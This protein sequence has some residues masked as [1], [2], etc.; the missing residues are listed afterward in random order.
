[1][2]DLIAVVAMSAIYP[3][4]IGADALWQTALNRQRCFR[5]IPAVRLPLDEY[6]STTNQEDSV[7]VA[8]AGLIEG[9]EFDLQQ[10]RIPRDLHAATDTTHWLALDACR[11]LLD[12]LGGEPPANPDRVGVVIGNSLT[13]EVSRANSI[14]L[15]WPYIQRVVQSVSDSAGLALPQGWMQQLE[16]AFKEPMPVPGSDTLAGGLSNTIAGRLTNYFDFHGLGYT[17]DGACASSLL[18]VMHAQSLLRDR[19]LDLAIAGGVDMSIDPFEM[20]GFSRLGALAGDTMR[21][22]DQS[23]TGFFP[24]EGCGLVA[25]MRHEDARKADVPVLAVL[26]GSGVSSD[27]A[28]GLTRPAESGHRM[29]AQRAYRQADV[30]PNDIGLFEGHGTGT[31]VGDIAELNVFHQ[32]R[33]PDATSAAVGSIKANIG[34][35]KAAAGVAGLIKTI[36]AVNQAI[37]PPT[38]GVDQPH[39]IFQQISNLRITHE[40]E[41]WKSTKRVAAV[42]ALGFG[43]INTHLVVANEPNSRRP[44]KM[45]QRWSSGEFGLLV[46]T[47][48]TVSEVKDILT[49]LTHKAA[50]FSDADCV[51]AAQTATRHANPQA[52]VRVAFAVTGRHSLRRAV[53]VATDRLAAIGGAGR[54]FHCDSDVAIGIGNPGR[55][56]ALFPGQGAPFQRHAPAVTEVLP[57]DSAWTQAATEALSAASSTVGSGTDVAQP[58]I[59]AAEMVGISWLE[60]IGAVP[61]G[62]VGHSLGELTAL[63]WA[64]MMTP[65]EAIELAVARGSAMQKYGV[66][67]TGMLAIDTDPDSA[68]VLAEQALAGGG[69]CELAAYNG[70]RQSV[71]GGPDKELDQLAEYAR[72][73]HILTHRLPVSHAFHT[74]AMKPAIDPYSA[75]IERVEWRQANP[76]NQVYSTVSGE[77]VTAVDDATNLLRRQLTNPVRLTQALQ[78]VTSDVD[79]LVEVGPGKTLSAAAKQFVDMPVVAMELQ[80]GVAGIGQ[81]TAALV[82]LGAVHTLDPWTTLAPQNERSFDH[83][84]RLLPSPLGMTETDLSHLQPASAVTE[85][86][87]ATEPTDNE[88]ASSID[89]ATPSTVPRTAS[90]HDETPDIASPPQPEPH[91]APSPDKS[92][93]D[94]DISRDDAAQIL[95]DALATATSLD[96]DQV[97]DQDRLSAD[98]HLNSLQINHLFAEVAAQAGRQVPSDPTGLAEG[99]VG[100]ALDLLMAL[101]GSDSADATA[102]L[103]APWVHT[104]TDTW[105][106]VEQPATAP[107]AAAPWSQS[108]PEGF[109]HDPEST[110]VHIVLPDN[111]GVEDLLRMRDVVAQ[112][113]D[114]IVVDH[115]G[116]GPAAA[117]VL[118]HETSAHP[119]GWT[120]VHRSDSKQ[121]DLEVVQKLPSGAFNDLKIDEDGQLYRRHSERIRTSDS[122]FRH[123]TGTDPLV[124]V[125]GGVNGIMAECA[126]ELAQNTNA[127]LLFVGRT[128]REDPAIIAALEG[129]AM[130]GIVADYRSLDV[131]SRTSVAEAL[132]SVT[133]HVQGIL[134][135][136]AINTPQRADQVTASALKA[137]SQAKVDGLHNLLEVIDASHLELV[138]TFGSIIE[139]AGLAGQLA[140]AHANEG[141]RR[142]TEDLATHSAAKVLHMQW[143]IW[144]DI[145]MGQDL[146]VL[147]SMRRRGVIPISPEAGRRH[148]WQQLTQGGPTTRLVMGRYPKQPTLEFAT[149]A[150][151]RALRYLEEVLTHIPETEL[152]VS[153]ELSAPTDKALQAHQIAGVS[154]LP[155]VC[156]LEAAAQVATTL[157]PELSWT[158]FRNLEILK[159]V[160]LS[161]TA[162]RATLTVSV[163]DLGSA[164][165]LRV[166]IGDD[167]GDVALMDIHCGSSCEKSWSPGGFAG[168]DSELYGPLYFH[169]E[170]F[171]R[172]DRIQHVTASGLQAQLDTRPA[173]WFSP[174]LSQELV[175][176]DVGVL[177]AT[178]HALQACFP[179]R[180]LLPVGADTVKVHN[181]A[182]DGPCLLEA[183]ELL[184]RGGDLCFDV[185]LTDGYGQPVISWEGLRLRQSHCLAGVANL[186]LMGPAIARHVRS[187]DWPGQ[188]DLVVSAAEDPAEDVVRYL[189]G[190][191]AGHDSAG[192]LWCRPGYTSTSKSGGFRLT[193]WSDEQRVGVDW[194]VDAA[195]LPR[196]SGEY[197][198]ALA[199][200]GRE[201]PERTAALVMWTALEAAKKTQLSYQG[202]SVTNVRP[203]EG[204]GT[205]ISLASGEVAVEVVVLTVSQR[206][207]VAGIGVSK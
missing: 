115:C 172:V 202:L 121:L 19:S 58:A 190:R 40:P 106:L 187:L 175:L 122:D 23:P 131:T 51:A 81:T 199:A 10:Y 143:S 74:Q 138:V 17:V 53:R 15:R 21:I 177:D 120:L 47:A 129:L 161:S 207:V 56:A 66:G 57:Q 113:W 85:P 176:G 194:E 108:T 48:D 101:P 149:A 69:T 200:L 92:P 191:E 76:D 197:D 147:D 84:P 173:T 97:T 159:P 75:A 181:P 25:L 196:L 55:F 160:S 118:F 163:A 105:T 184:P 4:G 185:D 104:F 127:R 37:I 174:F 50:Q 151:T 2:S 61:S 27:G 7:G 11:R 152:T 205:G 180:Q 156:A 116:A 39:Q 133:D 135:G 22:Y 102:L 36:N 182:P 144:S 136:A 18:S 125:T 79:L 130:R 14:R 77:V 71:I 158:T 132:G 204:L 186:E 30:Q 44:T 88:T 142:A 141:L 1:M 31:A 139:R 183:S 87:I 62:A 12:E 35:T 54:Y 145:G 112:G 34:H 126:T 193:A 64:Q 96:A 103:A 6:A 5:D 123:F 192:R 155:T 195:E 203:V 146:G 206:H 26:A 43:G 94:A 28:G 170:A 189:T 157:K 59:V 95:I 33:D 165:R 171:Q 86:S 52:R 153:G 24:G 168:V 114:R 13:G 16:E 148:F 140:Y 20:V 9:W 119:H 169:R 49:G 41:E 137:A 201:M 166:K 90:D 198:Q 178:I 162:E 38:T 98:L 109:S 117:R 80:S 134:H 93:V 45:P 70:P 67:A 188:I 42:S 83:Q 32:L 124:L 29:A 68:T 128:L 46:A 150:Q 89:T 3:S 63:A 78:T 73:Q 154:V 99:T 8:S 82:A 179:Q 107:V 111:P 91:V 65:A 100:D 164:E 60:A 110:H 167:K 72:R